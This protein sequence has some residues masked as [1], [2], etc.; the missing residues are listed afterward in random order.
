MTT[1]RSASTALWMTRSWATRSRRQ[2]VHLGHD[3][4]HQLHDQSASNAT[5]WWGNGNVVDPEGVQLTAQFCETTLIRVLKNYG[6]NPAEVFLT[7]FSRGAMATGDI[8]LAR[9]K[10]PTSGPASSPIFR[11]DW[12]TTDLAPLTAGPLSSWPVARATAAIP[13]VPRPINT[14]SVRVFPRS[15]TSSRTSGTPTPGSRAARRTSTCP[16]KRNSGSGWPRSSRPIPA[17]IAFP[18]PSPTR[19]ATPSRAF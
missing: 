16:F 6:G 8:G 10:W 17:R 15:S 18:A 4:L 3:A 11:E 5:M 2:G 7:G 14:S 12:S 9:H 19:K 13:R 1:Q